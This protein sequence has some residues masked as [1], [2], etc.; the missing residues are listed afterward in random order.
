MLDLIEADIIEVRRRKHLLQLLVTSVEQ[1]EEEGILPPDLVDVDPTYESWYE[2]DDKA[3]VA[4]SYVSRKSFSSSTAW[5]ISSE[6]RECTFHPKI[7]KRS[8]ELARTISCSSQRRKKNDDEVIPLNVTNRNNPI[9]K[10]IV[11]KIKAVYGSID[12]YHKHRRELTMSYKDTFPSREDVELKEC[13]FRPNVGNT[14]GLIP[15]TQNPVEGFDSFLKRLE[16][17]RE[18]KINAITA[19]DRKPGC[20]VIYSGK[21]TK[22]KP[23]S[24]LEP[25]RR[26]PSRE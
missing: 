21:P 23:F 5:M 2:E 8:R 14:T 12:N 15:T 6:E 25:P 1:D 24:F 17:A 18:I 13:T 7:S 26:I 22:V 11:E 20:G 16:K 9:N 19:N 10:A 4:A 3:T